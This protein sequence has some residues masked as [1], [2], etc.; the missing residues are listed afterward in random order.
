LGVETATRPRDTRFM[1]KAVRLSWSP[2][3]DEDQNLI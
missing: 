3:K 2:N 1:Q